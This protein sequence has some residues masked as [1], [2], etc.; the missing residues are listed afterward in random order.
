MRSYSLLS[1]C[2]S[3]LAMSG[4]VQ[5]VTENDAP[6]KAKTTP[7]S[8]KQAAQEPSAPPAVAAAAN[9]ASA[10]APAASEVVGRPATVAEAAKIIDFSTF[11][12]LPGAKGP[13]RRVV[14]SLSYEATGDLK[15]AFEFQRKALLDRGFKE[16]SP[17]QVY[18]QSATGDFGRDGFRVSV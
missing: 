18:D 7:P 6:A 11:P 17:P 2:G 1:I 13:G 4:C 9:S 12:I 5:A 16:L 10:E 14:A 15:A 3:L 8:A